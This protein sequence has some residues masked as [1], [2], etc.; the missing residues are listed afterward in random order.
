MGLEKGQCVSI[1]GDNCP[2]W[3]MIDMGVQMAGGVSVGIYTT[4]AWPE[5]EYVVTHSESVFLFAE[6]EEQL[7]KWLQFRKNAPLLKKVIVWDTK[8]LREFQDPLVMTYDDLLDHGRKQPTDAIEMRSRNISLQDLSVLIYTS[9]TTG[10]PKGAMLTHRNVTWMAE[11]IEAQN[12]MQTGDE[13]LSFLPLCHIFERLFSVFAHI[14][15]AYVVNFVEKPD[16]V[17]DNMSEVSPTVGYA[18]P[19][20][21]E[22]YYSTIQIRMSEATWFKRQVFNLAL[23]AGRQRATIK[24]NSQPV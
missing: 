6:N 1:I 13:V 4:N 20:I 9:G 12:P 5:V 24:M 23:K 21:W 11:A 2:E 7:D 19:R 22:K 18:V 14:R 10:P 17:T 8:G 15:H 3:V 16:T